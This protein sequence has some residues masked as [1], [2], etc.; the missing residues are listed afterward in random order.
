MKQLRAEGIQRLI[1]SVDDD[2]LQ[3][4]RLSRD[5]DLLQAHFEAVRERIIPAE[6]RVAEIVD[7]HRERTDA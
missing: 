4:E 7:N 6:N 1:E 2:L 3:L 5:D